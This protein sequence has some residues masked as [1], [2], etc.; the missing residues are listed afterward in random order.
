MKDKNRIVIPTGHEPE[1]MLE[2]PHFDAEETLLAARPVVPLTEDAIE[3]AR[4]ARAKA[5]TAPPARPRIPMLALIIIAAVSVGLAS[6]LAIGLYQGRQQTASTTSAQPSSRTTT[7][8]DAQSTQKPAEEEIKTSL[9]SVQPVAETDTGKPGE[10]TALSQPEG[11]PTN[12]QVA[13]VQAS[14]EDLDIPKPEREAAPDKKRADEKQTPPPAATRKKQKDIRA[15]DDDDD[16]YKRQRAARRRAIRE[17]NTDND[18]PQ[19]TDER[20]GQQLNRIRE[21]FE[22]SRP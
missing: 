21:I 9:P 11:D 16:D 10:P 1:E 14:P 18:V 4:R 5:S 12:E 8:A 15:N 22:G 6:G 19:R 20:V 7:V 3:A 13:E 17:Q 2:T